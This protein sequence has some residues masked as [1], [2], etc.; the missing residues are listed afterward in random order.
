MRDLQDSGT[1]DVQ[2]V[3]YHMYNGNGLKAGS[4]IHL[5]VTGSPAGESAELLPGQNTNLIVG[6]GALG[7]VLILA[8]GWMY[9]R[10]RS[11]QQV[12][13][14]AFQAAVNPDESP[15]NIMDAILALDDLYKDGKL[16][17]NAYIER[18]AELKGRLKESME[19][20]G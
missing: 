12:R 11:A 1:R 13:E 5:T 14:P 7:L 2:G 10:N 20:K 4:E 18:R 6:L 8:G 19:S 17:E 15:E 16:P 9:L 3:Q